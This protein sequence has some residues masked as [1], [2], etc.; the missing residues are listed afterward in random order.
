MDW[1]W[2]ALL[3]DESVC[4]RAR[5]LKVLKGPPATVTVDDTTSA[6]TGTPD[7]RCCSVCT[8]TLIPPKPPA[9]PPKVDTL[10]ETRASEELKTNM[11][12]AIEKCRRSLWEKERER[13]LRTSP[14]DIPFLGHIDEAVDVGIRIGTEAD[15][16]DLERRMQWVIREKRFIEPLMRAMTVCVEAWD[17]RP[18]EEALRA[19]AVDQRMQEDGAAFATHELADPLSDNPGIRA[20]LNSLVSSPVQYAQF[21]DPYHPPMIVECI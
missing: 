10:P 11:R 5:L 16:E 20:R 2:V 15:P 8:P 4:F 14:S 13:G 17:A 19:D 9:P 21:V 7:P 12:T 3:P 18:A 6:C 1:R